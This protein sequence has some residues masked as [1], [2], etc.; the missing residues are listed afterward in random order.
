MNEDF[1]KYL[2]SGNQAKKFLMPLVVIAVVGLVAAGG[3]SVYKNSKLP[4]AGIGQNQA[5]VQSQNITLN[6][7]FDFPIGLADSKESLQPLKITFQKAQLTNRILVG[8]NPRYAQ[9][10]GKY[11]MIF[12]LIENNNSKGITFR[13]RNIIRLIDPNGKKFAPS[14]YNKDAVVEADSVKKDT[15]GFFVP[16]SQKEFNIQYGLP[17]GTKQI[18]QLKFK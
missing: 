12:I 10:G 3:Y 16:D 2:K 1:S 6:Q 11:L 13:S 7:T 5:T 9:S 17:T 14:F 8:G 18:L 4:G 15:V